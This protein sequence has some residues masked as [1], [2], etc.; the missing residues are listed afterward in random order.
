[1][2]LLA[3]ASPAAAHH[4]GAGVGCPGGRPAL[5]VMPRPG[6]GYLHVAAR[7]ARPGTRWTDLRSANGDRPV[8][9][10]R[11]VRVPL[12]MLPDDL[13]QEALT[14]LFPADGYRDGAW[15]HLTGQ[16]PAGGC[17]EDAGRLAAWFG[18][19]PGL[20]PDVARRNGL[21]EGPLP[22][23]LAVR[24]P[25]EM[26]AARWTPA[27]AEEAPALTYGEDE[28]GAYAAYRLKPGE[29]LYSAVVIRFTGRLDA[30]E[31]NQLAAEIATRSG[32]E[33]VRDIPI[34]YPIKIP[35]ELLLPRY[36]PAGDPAR[37]AW[38]QGRL[39]A[40]RYRLQARARR[41]SG[42]HVI[43]DA[44]HG[45]IDVGTT[46][47]GMDEDEYVYDVM[48]R[49]KKKLER[50]TDAMVLATIEDGI[51]GYAARDLDRLPRDRNER[52]RTT[53]PYAPEDPEL[54]AL[55]VNLRWYLANSFYRRLVERGIDPEKV[56]FL[57]LHADS[58]HP[59]VSGAMAYIPGEEYRRGRYGSASAAYA[60]FE[61]V[62]DKT[63][64]SF[65][66]ATRLRAEGLSR[67]F[68][69]ALIRA[70]RAE[71]VPVHRYQPVRDHVIRRKSSW[72]PAVVRCSEAPVSVLVELVN[73]NNADDRQRMR[74]PEFRERL[75]AAFVGALLAV[76]DSA[77][78]P[79]PVSTAL[80]AGAP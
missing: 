40:D 69:E 56:V 46:K 49:I 7:Y 27:E 65:D 66:P 52:I 41:L 12:E 10:G 6:D 36:L 79:P 26:L 25:R 47:K 73:L 38:E 29:A 45:G 19:D 59:T 15:V 13:Q 23:G 11:A 61:E 80:A 78:E 5:L 28:A 72:V 70:F 39:A 53:P 33:D 50:E 48:C 20:G 35:R 34:G 21:P 2:A 9:V 4:E 63:F 32:I 76:Y 18:R 30:D 68:A 31:V 71:Q 77:P 1:L 37:V 57:S 17:R 16:R 3:L 62:R 75:A 55:G 51:T 58:L 43:L 42:L 74:L 64:V 24:I 22:A 8:Q 54:R 67:Q 60:S 44:G 14:R